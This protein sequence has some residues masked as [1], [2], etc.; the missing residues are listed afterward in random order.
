M[1]PAKRKMDDRDTDDD[2]DRRDVRQRQGSIVNGKAAPITP[3]QQQPP[4]PRANSTMAAAPA[5]TPGPPPRRPS[6][7]PELEKK[8]RKPKPKIYTEPPIWAQSARNPSIKLKRANFE[9]PKKRHLANASTSSVNGRAA[10]FRPERKSRNTSPEV[11]RPQGGQ[12]QPAPPPPQA[13]GGPTPAAIDP[14]AEITAILGPWEPTI[15]NVKPLD[16][17]NKAVADFLF[18]NVINSPDAVEIA[19]LGIAFEIEAKLGTVIDKDTN[20]RVAYPVGSEC[21]LRD[22]GQF[23]FRSSMTEVCICLCYT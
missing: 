1:T 17:L 5:P 12:Q 11:T 8:K 13:A 18:L 23:A 2:S 20:D 7:S 10:S 19:R 3:R 4:L 6:L 9:F 14:N 21:L 22:R 15:A 16:E